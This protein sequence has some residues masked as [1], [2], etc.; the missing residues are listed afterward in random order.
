MALRNYGTTRQLYGQVTMTLRVLQVPAAVGAN[1]T[2]F[3]LVALYVTR[4]LLL[5]AR[6]SQMRLS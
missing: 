3:G 4:L 6:P 2:R 1:P 5:D